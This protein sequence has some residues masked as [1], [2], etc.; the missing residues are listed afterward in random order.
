MSQIEHLGEYAK[1]GFFEKRN[2]DGIGKGR[3]QPHT[4][5]TKNEDM[6]YNINNGITLCKKCHKEIHRKRGY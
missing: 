6:I 1:R 5:E 4:E 2:I 3:K